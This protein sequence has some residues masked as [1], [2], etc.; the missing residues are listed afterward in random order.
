M[1]RLGPNFELSGV[2]LDPTL[3]D[4]RV[5]A[6]TLRFKEDFFGRPTP[7]SWIRKIGSP[8]VSNVFTSRSLDSATLSKITAESGILRKESAHG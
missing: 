3:Y 5:G 7:F 2:E 6:R 1:R 4:L 8:C